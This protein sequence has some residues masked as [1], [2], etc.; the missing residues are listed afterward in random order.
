MT[1]PHVTGLASPVQTCAVVAG[2]SAMT[3]T[4]PSIINLR[5][6][7]IISEMYAEKQKKAGGTSSINSCQ[8]PNNAPRHCARTHSPILDTGKP[9]VIK[10]QMTSSA[11]SNM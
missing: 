9:T 7:G 8:H 6:S 10:K 3:M 5:L 4:Y 2:N 11:P 1:D